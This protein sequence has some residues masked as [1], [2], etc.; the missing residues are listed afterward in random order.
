MAE[1]RVT[2]LAVEVLRSNDDTEER[3][4]QVAVEVLRLARLTEVSVSLTWP[5][6]KN[7]Q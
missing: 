7:A 5:V 1:Q 3:V 4:T 2:Q 6:E